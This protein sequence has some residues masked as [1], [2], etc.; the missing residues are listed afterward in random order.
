MAAE[1]DT[2]LTQTQPAI[3]TTVAGEGQPI[4]LLH[5]LG[6]SNYDWQILMPELVD[7]GYRCFAPD[8]PGHGDSAKPDV[9]TEYHIEIIY[10]QLE[11][12]LDAQ[13]ITKPAIFIGHSMGGYLSLLF[14]LR[15]PERVHGLVL[16]DPLFSPSQFPPFAGILKHRP[17]LGVKAMRFAPSWLIFALTGL[18]PTT[19]KYFSDE[20]RKRVA[21]DYKRAS[22]YIMYVT[23][24]FTE[25][26]PHLSRLYKPAMVVWGDSDRTLAPKKFPL[27]V[28]RLQNAAGFAI[29]GGGHQ[30]HLSHA[31]EVNP[32]ILAFVD[33]LQKSSVP[34]F[35]PASESL[36]ASAEKLFGDRQ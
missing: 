36:K 13:P 35:D 1:T 9:H 33:Q 7:A 30:P 6:A 18:D 8:L 34:E 5:G 32:K 28:D 4:V 11:A 29:R 14:S 20:E 22:P 12:W 3:N 19:S 2:V 27:L 15:R 25:L 26:L 21:E 17:E 23:S 10:N 31:D 24:T 16:V